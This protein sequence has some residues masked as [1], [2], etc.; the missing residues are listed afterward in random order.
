MSSWLL[1]YIITLFCH[2]GSQ[3]QIYSTSSIRTVTGLAL[4]IYSLDT[5]HSLFAFRGSLIAW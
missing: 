5:V 3:C 2:L 1:P 4:Y